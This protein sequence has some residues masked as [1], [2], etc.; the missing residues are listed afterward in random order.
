MCAVYLKSS[1][2]WLLHL[3]FSTNLFCFSTQKSNGTTFMSPVFCFLKS[4]KTLL[5]SVFCL[6][7]PLYD[8]NQSSLLFAV[9]LSGIQNTQ[10]WAICLYL[11]FK[12]HSPHPMY[13]LLSSRKVH[14]TWSHRHDHNQSFLFFAICLK[15]FEMRSHVWSAP[16]SYSNVSTYDICAL[17]SSF[18]NNKISSAFQNHIT[19]RFMFAAR[20]FSVS[21]IPPT[22][23]A[24]L[25]CACGSKIL[26]MIS[27]SF[28]CSKSVRNRCMAAPLFS[29]PKTDTHWHMEYVWSAEKYSK[30]LRILRCSCLCS[31]YYIGS[32]QNYSSRLQWLL[33]FTISQKLRAMMPWR[34]VCSAERYSKL[35]QGM[36]CF[37]SAHITIAVR[38]IGFSVKIYSNHT[39]CPRRTELGF[40]KVFD[41]SGCSP[42][43]YTSLATSL[44]TSG[45]RPM[46]QILSTPKCQALPACLRSA[47]AQN[48]SVYIFVFCHPAYSSLSD[49]FLLWIKMCSGRNYVSFFCLRTLYP[50]LMHLAASRQPWDYFLRL[51]SKIRFKISRE[52]IASFNKKNDRRILLCSK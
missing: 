18:K 25:L 16:V 20:C 29:L 22:I 23:Y 47:S 9:C 44:K 1:L 30:Y 43:F 3:S 34:A 10:A 52:L 46:F 13:F 11:R 19:N 14:K 45:L 33:L 8:Q 50:T 41:V 6:P 7:S 49:L 39:M 15:A 27:V 40:S 21:Q 4:S 17:F 31:Y 51:P 2:C 42:P 38:Y 28:I 48:L 36:L 24:C 32:A 35:P 26:A 37:A 5:M 12:N